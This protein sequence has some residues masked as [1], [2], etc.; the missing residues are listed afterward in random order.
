MS[1]VL[2][3]Q[4]YGQRAP[5]WLSHQVVE[6]NNWEPHAMVILNAAGLPT[7]DF[8]FVIVVS[9]RWP[10]WP[11]SHPHA[12][13]GLVLLLTFVSRGHS[14]SSMAHRLCASAGSPVREVEVT[15]VK[16]LE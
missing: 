1:P 5:T 16:S 3:P 13:P 12:A 2:H 7:H 9:E 8:P 10:V 11:L 4:L 6:H 14:L 15:G